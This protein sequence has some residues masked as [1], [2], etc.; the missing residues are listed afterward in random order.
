M[1]WETLGYEIRNLFLSQTE[2]SVIFR[3]LKSKGDSFF[4]L[5]SELFRKGFVFGIVDGGGRTGGTVPNHADSSL[6]MLTCQGDFIVPFRSPGGLALLHMK[7][8][9]CEENKTTV[10]LTQ[11]IKEMAS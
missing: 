7:S 3:L 5:D 9:P 1:K 10:S 6:C 8:V 2:H 4:P 11:F